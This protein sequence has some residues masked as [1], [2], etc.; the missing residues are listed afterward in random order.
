MER[1]SRDRLMTYNRLPS[2]REFLILCRRSRW[3]YDL[4]DT[5]SNG[6]R[7]FAGSLPDFFDDVATAV[8]DL[9]S[10]IPSS[11]TDCSPGF[12][13]VSTIRYKAS[14]NK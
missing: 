14:Y 3:L 8:T 10:Y 11:V 9:S 5:V 12:F 4:L 13:N 1:V 6:I 2:A 7:R